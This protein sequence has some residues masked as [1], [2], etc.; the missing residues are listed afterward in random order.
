MC[1]KGLN[2]YISVD[3][4]TLA[5]D[6]APSVDVRSTSELHSVLQQGFGQSSSYVPVLQWL[7]EMQ[8]GRQVPAMLNL[9]KVGPPRGG[10]VEP[11]GDPSCPTN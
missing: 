4:Q 3:D 11:A 7:K 2:Y 1:S 10:G 5:G 8:A 6:L 9:L